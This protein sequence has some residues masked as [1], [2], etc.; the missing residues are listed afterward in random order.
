MLLILASHRARNP[1][2]QFNPNYIAKVM[3]IHI[4]DAMKLLDFL[5]RIFTIDNPILWLERLKACLEK[6]Q[7][8]YQE[9][10]EKMMMGREI[11]TQPLDTAEDRRNKNKNPC[12]LHYF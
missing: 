4:D 9:L 6:D 2:I 5:Q 11:I 3:H 10:K 8:Y 12:I 7:H 1:D